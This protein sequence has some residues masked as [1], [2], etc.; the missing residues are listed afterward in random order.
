MKKNIGLWEKS[1]S[2]ISFRFSS[3]EMRQLE[4]E[5]DHE[6][7]YKGQMYDVVELN[8]DKDSTI[9]HCV[10]DEKETQLID[11]YFKIQHHQSTENQPLNYLIKLVNSQFVPPVC[12]YPPLLQ[13]EI[14][15]SFTLYQF[16]FSLGFETVLTPPPR[17]C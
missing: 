16:P 1:T 17:F 8:N 4:W 10:S 13:K 2:L 7:N 9:I 15:P 12:E 14:T 11:A 6:F 3:E 5:N